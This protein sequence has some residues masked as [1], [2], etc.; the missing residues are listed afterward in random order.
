MTRPRFPLALTASAAAL[1]LAL[2]ACSGSGD[3]DPSALD[4]G[5]ARVADGGVQRM[6][7]TSVN[8]RPRS[9]LRQGGTLQWAVDR[10]PTQWNPLHVDGTEPATTAVM[11]ALLPTFWR[12]DAGGT[13]TPNQA[14][15]LSAVS[16][17][18]DGRQTVTWTL[19]PKAHWSD[20]TPITWRDLAA[21]WRAL[22][23]SDPDYRTASTTG[24]DRVESVVRGRDDHQAVMVFRTRFSEWQAMFNNAAD[25]PLLPAKY[26][27]TAEEFNTA[28]TDRIPATAGPFRPVGIDRAKGT[29]T[30]EADP[31]WWGQKPM[32]DRIVFRVTDP[33]ATAD[34]FARGGVDYADIGPDA[35][36]YKQASAVADGE[37]RQAGGPNIRALVLNGRSEKLSD[38]AVRRAV[39]QAIDREAIARS[40]LKGINWPYTPMNNHFLVPGQNGYRDNSGGLSQ[41]DVDAADDALEQAGWPRPGFAMRSRGGEPLTLR[42]VVPDASPV[43]AA[44][45][46]QVLEMLALAGIQVD[47]QKVPNAEFLDRYVNRHDFD[48]TLISISGTPFPATSLASTFQQ[49][50][51]GNVSQVG[52]EALDRAIADA[53]SSAT[54]KEGYEAI[55]RADAEAWRVAGLIPLYQRPAILAARRTV[56]NLGAPG[57]SDPVYEDIGFQK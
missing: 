16:E 5:T 2:C 20:G 24:F 46:T 44:E 31:G 11:K 33:A 35:A 38:P 4:A 43:A 8:P 40:G 55:N 10:L 27:G 39:L 26:T 34:A 50:A 41:Y 13:Q 37:I 22:N 52:S 17:M 51:G 14:Y 29:V 45:S 28:Y 56:A 1:A 30:L 49:G 48:L 42:L 7:Q 6:T 19:N 18:R 57:L 25:C 12:S 53:A 36:A 47:V 3:P 23:G 32:L 15:L 9:A 54:A 21:T